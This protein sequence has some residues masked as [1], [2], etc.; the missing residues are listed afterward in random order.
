M[1]A[2]ASLH[3]A[4][5]ALGLGGG[6]AR[7]LARPVLVTSNLSQNRFDPRNSGDEN[8]QAW[9]LAQNHLAFVVIRGLLGNKFSQLVRLLVFWCF[10][11]LIVFAAVER[12]AYCVTRSQ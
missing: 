6:G 5:A 11:C 2:R 10:G 3:T 9:E 4:A 7:T 12:R 8:A 1:P